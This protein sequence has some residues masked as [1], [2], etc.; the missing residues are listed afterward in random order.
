[1]SAR[2]ALAHPFLQVSNNNYNDNYNIDSSCTKTAMIRDNNSVNN[3]YNNDNY[4]SSNN[5]NVNNSNYSNTKTN[6]NSVCSDSCPV[7]TMSFARILS[8]PS[9]KKANEAD[10]FLYSFDSANKDEEHHHH[11]HQHL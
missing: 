5:Y 11:H 8:H 3:N 9:S 2:D 7:N 6:S 10:N 1:M 4:S